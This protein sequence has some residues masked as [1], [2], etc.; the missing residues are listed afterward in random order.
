MAT[1]L[2]LRFQDLL[3]DLEHYQ[4]LLADRPL[5]LP[6]REYALL[7]YLA[8][9]AGRA[10][11]KRQLR[12]PFFT[13]TSCATKSWRANWP[14]PADMATGL[15][16]SRFVSSRRTTHLKSSMPSWR[17]PAPSQSTPPVDSRPAQATL[18]KNDPIGSGKSLLVNCR[19]V[20]R[21]V[22]GDGGR[23]P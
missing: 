9:R 19:P 2:Q 11:S 5:M 22:A 1:T 13:V 20:R 10:V 7:V 15:T 12:S 18:S 6:Y 4:V 23:P 3:I 8:G 14:I 21:V 16:V 17:G